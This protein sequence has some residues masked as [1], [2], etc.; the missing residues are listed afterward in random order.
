MPSM[1]AL[2]TLTSLN[3]QKPATSLLPLTLPSGMLTVLSVMPRLK[4]RCS[5]SGVGST[6]SLMPSGSR[7]L[8]VSISDSAMLTIRS[9]SPALQGSQTGFRIRN[10]LD[11]D[12][13]EL[14]RVTKVVGVADQRQVIAG[15]PFL[16]GEG[17]AGPGGLVDLRILLEPGLALEDMSGE[18]ATAEV[19]GTKVEQGRPGRIEFLRSGSRPSDHRACR[20]CRSCHNRRG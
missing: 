1:I 8:T 14:C 4:N 7:V 10:E 13:V 6:R 9:T 18:Q 12:V 20:C 15:H 2:R 5:N 3:G 19:V 16:D 17:S 11:V